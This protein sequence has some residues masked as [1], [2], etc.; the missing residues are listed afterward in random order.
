MILENANVTCVGKIS[1]PDEYSLC[2]QNLVTDVPTD[3][4]CGAEIETDDIY[5]D[6]RVVG[7]DYGKRFRGM[8]RLKTNDFE[9]LR[10]EVEWDGNWVPFVDSLL[11]TMI[12][13][14]PFRKLMVPVMIKKLRCDP[15]VLYE[16]VA[17]NKVEIE[18][19]KTVDEEMVLN[20][21]MKEE[22]VWIRRQRMTT[23]S[24]S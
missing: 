18:T 13:G 15:K 1:S 8:R 11:Q 2:V 14:M 16:A 23:S 10:G 3:E 22:E 6:L 20:D 17:A 4:F 21:V 24:I 9:V 12:A 5:K 19:Q 7:Y